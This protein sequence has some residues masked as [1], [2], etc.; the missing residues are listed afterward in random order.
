MKPEKFS[1]ISVLNSDDNCVWD[2]DKENLKFVSFNDKTK[3]KNQSMA[4]DILNEGLVPPLGISN[5]HKK[6]ITGLGVNVGIIDQ[7]IDTFHPEYKKS[8]RYYMPTLGRQSSMHGPAVASLLVGKNITDKSDISVNKTEQKIKSTF[9]I[10][11]Y[12][13]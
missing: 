3:F 6:G 7:P 10:Q 2:S 4:T 5:I 1:D 8:I 12:M 9:L 13:S 11:E